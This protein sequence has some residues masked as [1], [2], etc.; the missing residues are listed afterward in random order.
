MKLQDKIIKQIIAIRDTGATNMF[1]SHRV[2]E[3]CD[4]LGF[5]ELQEFIAKNNIG[6]TKF[7]LTGD[8]ANVTI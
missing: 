1:D 2:S 8:P 6:Y 4:V 3:I 5:D 7:I